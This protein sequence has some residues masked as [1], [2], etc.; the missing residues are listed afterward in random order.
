MRHE[1]ICWGW[2]LATRWAYLV[3]DTDA[4]EELIAMLDSQA[5]GHVPP[6]LRAERT[7]ARA[8]LSAVQ[9]ARD[10]DAAFDDAV[11]ALR[12]VASPYHL[13][14]GLLDRAEYRTALGDTADVA[15]LIDEAAAIA[16]KL[17]CRPLVERSSAIRASQ[18]SSASLA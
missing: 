2:P 14:H 11:A 5:V 12:E 8:R 3:G 13:A 7:L 17:H 1:L 15:V 9:R 10:A 18:R 4:V 6:I 16:E